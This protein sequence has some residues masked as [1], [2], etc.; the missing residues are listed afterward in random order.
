LNV[1]SKLR[2]PISLRLISPEGKVLEQRTLSNS[3]SIQIGNDYRPGL[4][5][6]IVIQGSES[7][8]VKLV[9]LKE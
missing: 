4:Y 1:D 6:A 9:K 7:V 3:Q 5:Y 8:V 2:T